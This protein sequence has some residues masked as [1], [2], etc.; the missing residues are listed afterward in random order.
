LALLVF[1]LSAG[2]RPVPA[3]GDPPV[4]YG[5]SWQLF[6]SP[7]G[8]VDVTAG[9]YKK[10]T[11]QDKAKYTIAFG[12][13][14][15][16]ALRLDCNRA[17]GTWTSTKPGALHFGPLAMTRAMCPAGSL[18]DRLAS[19]LSRV[20]VYSFLEGHLILHSGVVDEDRLEFE[21]L[22]APPSFDCAKP[23]AQYEKLV[24]SDSNL[25]WL[26]RTLADVY[27][28]WLKKFPSAESVQQKDPEPAWL[29]AR[30]SC[31]NQPD[32]KACIES[33]YQRRIAQLEMQAGLL[34]EPIR[35]N[36]S[37]LGNSTITAAY[38]NQTDPA[39]AL[40]TQ[41]DLQ[42]VALVLPSGSGAR[43]GAPGFEFWEHQGEAAVTWNGQKFTC[44]VAR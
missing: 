26:D 16:A 17:T 7:A 35:A 12:A 36:Y 43:Y 9:K 30:E 4:L 28:A 38:Y 11:P 6:A 1:A 23:V 14:G 44:K 34:P 8:A 33:A 5:T 22:A 19:D 24:C 27:S 41:A 39:S 10:F 37:C 20:V 21:P 40:F 2:A 3:L 13:D 31:A 42:V 29:P 18:S 32:A 15:R 25:S